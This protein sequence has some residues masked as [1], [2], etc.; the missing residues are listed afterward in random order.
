MVLFIIIFYRNAR[1]TAFNANNIIRLCG[2]D[3]RVP[4]SGYFVL[5]TNDPGRL[6][7]VPQMPMPM[8]GMMTAMNVSNP[9]ALQML[10]MSQQQAYA[11]VGQG[12][13][14]IQEPSECFAV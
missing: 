8:N 6:R 10:M 1:Y 7:M 5:K 9:Q 2:H 12:L 13:Y 4:R 14:C 11:G 3:R